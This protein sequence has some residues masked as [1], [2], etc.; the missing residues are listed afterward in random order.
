[1]KAT[2][3]RK[4]AAKKAPAK[5]ARKAAPKKAAPVS[6]RSEL[7]A[8]G[9]RIW[10]RIAIRFV[11]DKIPMEIE[12]VALVYCSAMGDFVVA[13]RKLGQPC[14]AAQRQ[15]LMNDCT[16]AA[17]I[18]RQY[19]SLLGLV[20]PRAAAQRDQGPGQ[21]QPIGPHDKIEQ[22]KRQLDTMRADLLGSTVQ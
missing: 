11:D 7:N 21:K 12:D 3:K 2:R 14:Q 9:R 10:D 13:R 20:A 16:R 15:Q 8:T 18:A 17:R 5:R 19:A 22:A 6:L 4:K 1:M